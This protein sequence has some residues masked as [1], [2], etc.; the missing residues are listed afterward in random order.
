M[1]KHLIFILILLIAF[2]SCKEGS[3]KDKKGSI[4]VATL[5]GPSAISMIHMIENTDSLKDRQLNFQIQNEPLQIRPLLFQEKV[6]YAVVPTNMAS[7]LYNKGVNYQLAA[8]PVWGTLY[9][10]GENEKI[11][12]WEDLRGKKIH[13][14]AKGMTPDVMFRYLL[15]KNHID[16]QQDVELDYSFPTHI[17]LANAV[18]S[19]K[20]KL[21]VISEPLVSMVMKKNNR[22]KPVMSLNEEWK[23][24]TNMEIP[25]TALLVNIDYARENKKAVQQFLNKYKSSVDWVNS[26]HETGAELIVKHN[27]LNSKEVALQ[28][29]PRCNMRFSYAYK[30]NDLVSNY[31]EIFYRMNPD[32]VGGKIPDEDFYYKK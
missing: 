17:E 4:E 10:F 8:V 1:R 27:I 6:E 15:E 19:G 16:P 24:Q 23:K 2:N 26:N 11:N 29:I 12:S 25:Q 31:L 21:G 30:I 32:I 28:A 14:M 7:I 3:N 22:V 18:A 20:A 5:R 9:L 13:L